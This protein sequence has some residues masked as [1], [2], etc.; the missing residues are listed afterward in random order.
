MFYESSSVNQ[1][2][3]LLQAE[4]TPT[5]QVC[6]MLYILPK[7][8]PDAFD[9]FVEIIKDDY[10]WLAATLETSLKW[11]SEMCLSRQAS[12]INMTCGC[13]S[14]SLKNE[15]Q[16]DGKLSCFNICTHLQ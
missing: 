12:L 15:T 10:P 6:K 1:K 5:E 16:V 8:G 14:S 2:H 11:E 7:R 9:S 13:G 4:K 3:L